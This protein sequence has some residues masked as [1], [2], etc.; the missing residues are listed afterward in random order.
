M[1]NKY[2]LITL[3]F[4]QSLF[5][6]HTPPF[7]PPNPNT[8]TELYCE[9]GKG[10]STNPDDL[11]NPECPDLKNNFDWR[12]QT[13]SSTEWYPVIG[14]NGNPFNIK[15]PF[16][17][18]S[19]AFYFGY[20]SAQ[21]GSNYN[22]E[23]GWELLKVEFG[24]YGNIDAN[25][26]SGWY[27][28]MSN[29]NNP[30]LPYMILYNKYSGTMRFFGTLLAKDRTFNN[31][32]IDLI[33]PNN[34]S[35]TD[36]NENLKST[37]LLSI[38]GKA[39]QPLD[40]ET[41]NN[42]MTV[43]VPFTNN[44][45]VFFWFD[46]PLA[47]DPCV[48]NNKIQLDVLF[49]IFQEGDIEVSA[50]TSA[51]VYG[52]NNYG[53]PSFGPYLATGIS[54][55]SL[56]NEDGSLVAVGSFLNLVNYFSIHPNT[57]QQDKI[58]LASLKEYMDCSGSIFPIMRNQQRVSS[59]EK[60]KH[61]NAIEIIDANIS[62]FSSLTNSCHLGSNAA[63]MITS[64]LTASGSVEES[65][66]LSNTK[67]S[68]SLPGSNWSD[69][70]LQF[71]DYVDNNGKIVPA[72]PTY[73][74]RLGVLALLETPKVKIER[75]GSHRICKGNPQAGGIVC[76]DYGRVRID[77][78]ESLKYS[79]NPIM[80]I[81]LDASEIYCRFVI[82]DENNA[83]WL[84]TSSTNHYFSHNPN[85]LYPVTSDYIPID[86]FKHSTFSFIDI[87][88]F[89]NSSVFSGNESEKL[90]LQMKVLLQ[91]KD[92]GKDGTPNA[93]YHVFTFPVSIESYNLADFQ[94]FS[95]FADLD[96]IKYFKQ[97]KVFNTDTTFVED[98][99]L[100]FNG[101]LTINAKLSVA[102][103]KT[104]KIYAT[105][106][107]KTLNNAEVD[108]N[109]QLIIGY[110]FEKELMPPVSFQEVTSFCNSTNYK[111]QFESSQ[112][113]SS[114]RIGSIEVFDINI[115]P[116]PNNGI[117]TLSFSQETTSNASITISSTRGEM[118]FQRMI[119]EGSRALDVDLSHLLSG[120]YFIT[121]DD[122]KNRSSKKLIVNR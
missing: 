95:A 81:D 104:V 66:P 28:N 69:T 21:Q 14:P 22:P 84:D 101:N 89:H 33:I 83:H 74:E 112:A 53:N 43:F 109:I 25:N 29:G 19:D 57:S 18:P 64:Y 35:S 2:L 5:G 99:I 91:S 71:N 11:Q 122:G 41:E 10:I 30:R 7:C 3:F 94:D 38:Q 42:S 13:L 32:K 8:N 48:C 16:T 119:G 39:M 6:Q 102:P 100:F 117:F 24:T 116:N 20:V 106:G 113:V 12:A 61:K 44:S 78:M 65:E 1:K 92:L 31:L 27:P 85:S 40:Q 54:P 110:P 82:R 68:L 103:G 97:D 45:G 73:N 50:T 88:N 121:Y 98:V 70:K 76:N 9:E 17:G 75:A 105:Q 115:Q 118:V 108:A 111:A 80:N 79:F 46:I 93:S 51:R 4:V 56:I 72:Y 114:Q 86:Y 15:N 34:S 107:I 77:L 58:Y 52:R 59:I 49:S 26:I 90:Y 87:L 63:T 120:V 23:D 67:I 37:N 55:G 62:Y 60:D 96:K 47:Y 36:Y